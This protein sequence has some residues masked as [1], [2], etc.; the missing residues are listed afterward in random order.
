MDPFEYVNPYIAGRPVKGTEMFFGRDGVFSFVQKHLKGRHLNAPIV[1][2]GQRRTGKTSV[3]Y[4]MQRHLGPRYRC[5][6][7]DL[8]GFT[9]NSVDNL[10]W[11]IANSIQRGL[12][13][14]KVTLPDRDT[15]S[16]N[17]KVV[18]ETTFLDTVWSSLGRAESHRHRPKSSVTCDPPAT[19]RRDSDTRVVCSTGAQM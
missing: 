16:A 7:I 9:P 6:L 3:L 13:Q 8:H 11:D 4:Q 12:Q 19:G 2:Y 17:P 15:F 5:I 18:F 10:L 1:L 14:P